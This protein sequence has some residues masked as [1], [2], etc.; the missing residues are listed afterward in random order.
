MDNTPLSQTSQAILKEITSYH[1]D[2]LQEFESAG[3]RRRAGHDRTMPARLSRAVD[4]MASPG[5]LDGA[6]REF[7]KETAR[8]IPRG[9]DPHRLWLPFHALTRGLNVAEDGAG[10]FLVDQMNL[11]A[12]DLLRPWSVVLQGGVTVVE[13]LSSNTGLNVADTEVSVQWLSDETT[14]AT[15]SD[16][17]FVQSL[18]KPK[19]AIGVIEASR[20]FLIQSNAE[21]WIRRH[22]LRAAG[23]IIDTAV[24]DGSGTHGEP[25][26]ILG[27]DGVGTQTGSGLTW[28]GVLHMKKLAADKNAQDGTISFIGTTAVRELLEARPKETGGGNYVW[29]GNEIASCPAFATTVMPTATLLCGPMAEVFLGLWGGGMSVEVNPY[30]PTLFKSGIVQIRVVISVDLALGCAPSA[31]T[32]ATGVS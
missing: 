27:I 29:Q 19:I 21:P 10:G 20:Q 24:L 26:G 14:E 25:D 9:Y 8:L 28:A 18:L 13:A 22:L 3:R 1:S 7:A 30:D 5:G 11:P 6:E 32:K 31:F 16:P 2:R 15:P 12:R 4:Q 23:K 17:S